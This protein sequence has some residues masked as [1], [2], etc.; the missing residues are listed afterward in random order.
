MFASPSPS[1]HQAD[2]LFSRK[3]HCQIR[4]HYSNLVERLPDKFLV[5]EFTS[6]GF[7]SRQ[8]RQPHAGGASRRIRAAK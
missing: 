6:I 5:S 8:G 4:I 1:N 7:K 2:L 3:R